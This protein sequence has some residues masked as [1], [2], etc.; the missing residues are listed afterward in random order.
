MEMCLCFE[1]FGFII[2]SN[3]SC[4]EMLGY[5]LVEFTDS[6]VQHEMAGQA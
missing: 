2:Q 6:T 5:L 4:C 1:F 3:I